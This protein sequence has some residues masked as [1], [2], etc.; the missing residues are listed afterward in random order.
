M[1]IFTLIFGILCLLQTIFYAGENKINYEVF[2]GI[3]TIIL[4]MLTMFYRIQE[5]I[6][7]KK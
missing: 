2:Y 1:K 3:C 4:F 7:G 5:I 6:K